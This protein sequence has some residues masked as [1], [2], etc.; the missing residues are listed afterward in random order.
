LYPFLKH[1]ILL[2]VLAERWPDLII[3]LVV[4]FAVYWACRFYYTE[5]KVVKDKVEHADCRQNKTIIS[6]LKD[7]NREIKDA[8]ILIQNAIIAQNPLML[9]TFSK[10]KSPRQLNEMGVRLFEQSG[11][12]KILDE[13]MAELVSQIENRHPATAYDVEQNAYLVLMG[14]TSEPWFNP[15]KEYLYN[16]PVFEGNNINLGAICFVMSLVLRNGYFEIHPE[17]DSERE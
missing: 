12:G 6:E 10:S 17:I 2:G 16:N 8:I 13:H 4:A 15:L 1:L 9:G 14:A 7:T 11:A 3:V 5:I